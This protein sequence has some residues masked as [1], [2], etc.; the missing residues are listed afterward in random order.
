MRLGKLSIRD[1]SDR[2][3]KL[4]NSIDIY[5]IYLYIIKKIANRS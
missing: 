1:V 2:L 3:Q 4:K 5:R